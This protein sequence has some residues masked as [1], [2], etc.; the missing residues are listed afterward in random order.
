MT[1]STCDAIIDECGFVFSAQVR[2]EKYENR[3]NSRAA[4]IISDIGIHER[5]T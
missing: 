1:Q 4:R 3:I 2:A 5:S